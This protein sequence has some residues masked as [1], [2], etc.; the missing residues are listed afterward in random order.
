MGLE[1]AGHT[2]LIAGTIKDLLFDTIGGITV[3]IWVWW[4]AR[5]N[6]K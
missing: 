3:A 4:R 1:T 6:N 2:S 5:N